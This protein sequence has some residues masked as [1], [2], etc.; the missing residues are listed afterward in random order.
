MLNIVVEMMRMRGDEPIC[1][2]ADLKLAYFLPENKRHKTFP[3]I[4]K[5]ETSCLKFDLIT[6]SGIFF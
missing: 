4:F 3:E 1:C 6:H 5:T 2:R